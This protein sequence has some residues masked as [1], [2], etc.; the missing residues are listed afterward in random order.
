MSLRWISS[1]ILII[2]I[3]SCNNND[4]STVV[5]FKGKPAEETSNDNLSRKVNI[6][7]AS[8]TSPKETLIYYN[9]LIKYIESKTGYEINI[10]Q[11]KKYS[12]INELI[13]DSKVD[14]AFICSGALVDIY[15]HGKINILAAPQIDGKKTYNAYIIINKGSSIESFEDLKGKKFAFTDPI[16]NTGTLYP[17]QELLRLGVDAKSFFSETTYTY[18]HDISIEMVNNGMIDAASVNS[19]IYDY[20]VL[21][22]SDKISNTKILYVSPDYGMPPVVSPKKL[23]KKR[24]KMYQKIFLE[25]ENDTTAM[26]ILKK[27]NIE[28]YVNANIKEY[29]SIY[30]LK[31]E[32]ER[33]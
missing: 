10:I 16:S 23:D 12:E 29:K 21:N 20:L 8:M 27:L 1:L 18:A 6:A 11:K 26:E 9:E 2:T 4:N 19:L 25:L 17:K 32:I 22:S 3:A 15:N 31:E 13:E 14:F 33:N 5:D 30:S 28:K 24:F 7:I